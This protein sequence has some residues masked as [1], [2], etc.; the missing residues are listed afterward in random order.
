MFSNILEAS[1]ENKCN[2][3]NIW[4]CLNNNRKTCVGYAWVYEDSFNGNYS[5]FFERKTR[6]K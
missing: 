6:S 3:R 4:L 5:Y 1:R 2:F